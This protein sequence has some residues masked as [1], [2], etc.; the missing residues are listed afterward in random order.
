[1]FIFDRLRDPSFFTDLLYS[2]PCIIVAL[3]CHEWAHAYVAYRCGDST[4]RLMGRMTLN[5]L[6]HMDPIGTLLMIFVG[7]GW[8][9]PVPVNPFNFRHRI[10]DDVKVSMAGIVTNLILYLLSTVILI[11]LFRFGS[12]MIQSY[13]SI[14]TP[15]F[16]VL[17]TFASINFALA[18]FNLLPI[19]PL[20]GSHLITD[21]L[22]RGRLYLTPQMQQM[23]RFGLLILCF[24]TNIVSQLLNY[25]FVHIDGF[26]WGLA[27]LI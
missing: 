1:M 4:A 15:V 20:D 23:A 5:P 24:G 19:P 9:K 13:N 6:R 10:A 27:R 22:L 12:D 8:A 14:I 25:L 16:R 11:L 2:L 7:F 21:L 18:F 17:R 3:S 26:L